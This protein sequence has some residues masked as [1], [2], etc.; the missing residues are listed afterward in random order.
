MTVTAA[1]LKLSDR[2]MATA[3]TTYELITARGGQAEPRAKL[4]AGERV[5]ILGATGASGRIA[6]QLAHGAEAAVRVD[7]PRDQLAA[8]IWRCAARAYCCSAAASAARPR[9]RRP[10]PPTT[11]CSRR[12]RAGSDRRV[13]FVP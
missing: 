2:W 3:S 13:V 6:A 9:S 8:A 5:L 7:R 4:T 1:A 10:P 11:A 12:P